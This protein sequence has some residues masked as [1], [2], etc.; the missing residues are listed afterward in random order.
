[1]WAL[2]VSCIPNHSFKSKRRSK[3]NL[4]SSAQPPERRHSSE[5]SSKEKGK[6]VTPKLVSFG[7][8][9]PWSLPW[10]GGLTVSLMGRVELGREPPA[11]FPCATRQLADGYSFSDRLQT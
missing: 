7:L 2:A 8:C 5:T 10:W 4:P 3:E 6:E 11:P 1:M 9:P